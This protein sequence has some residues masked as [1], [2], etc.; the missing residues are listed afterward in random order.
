MKERDSQHK[1]LPLVCVTCLCLSWRW[2][3]PAAAA[4]LSGVIWPAL[5]WPGYL[6]DTVLLSTQ[7]VRPPA[8]LAPAH[9]PSGKAGP[10]PL[11]R[12]FLEAQQSG[13]KTNQRT[14]GGQRR[15]REASIT[16]ES[17]EQVRQ[18]KSKLC[19]LAEKGANSGGKWENRLCLAM[20]SSLPPSK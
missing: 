13:W 4:S 15:Q 6:R 20:A 12:S 2:K 9:S 17:V 19:V 10:L 8:S 11:S 7:P 3:L 5:P 1:A 16:V 18:S 14:M